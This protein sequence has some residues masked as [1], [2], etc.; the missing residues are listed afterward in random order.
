MFSIFASINVAFLKLVLRMFKDKILPDCQ[1]ENRVDAAKGDP[2]CDA[3]VADYAAAEYV[4][5]C[6]AAADDT[7][8]VCVDP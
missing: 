4:V 5:G 3:A 6:V 7:V 1:T 8:V 2:G